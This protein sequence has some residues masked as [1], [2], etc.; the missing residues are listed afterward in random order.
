MA[1]LEQLI[2]QHAKRIYELSISLSPRRP[3]LPTP[4]PPALLE[5]PLAVPA[6]LGVQDVSLQDG[7]GADN[8]GE[9]GKESTG[10][11]ATRTCTATGGLVRQMAALANMQAQVRGTTCNVQLTTCNMQ[12]TTCTTYNVQH[13]T[14]NMQRRTCNIQHAAYNM[15][16]TTCN[17][18]HATCNM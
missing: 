9:G 16:R 14:Y 4:S 1:Q 15:Q 10:D 6:T 5:P 11:A 17:V 13:A 18:E 12:R 2:S 3:P 7:H 8:G